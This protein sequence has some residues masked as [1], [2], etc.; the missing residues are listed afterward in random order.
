MQVTEH[1]YWVG[2]VSELPY[3][4]S[5]RLANFIADFLGDD[6]SRRV[7]DLGCGPANFLSVLHD[8]GFTNLVGLE[9][10]PLP[11]EHLA[12]PIV[13]KRDLA[14]PICFPVR[15]SAI[16]L[17]VAEHIPSEHEPTLLGNI[18]AA[19]A[20]GG[21]LVLSWAL[22]DQPGLGHTNGVSNEVAIAKLEAVGFSYLPDPTAVARSIEFIE[23]EGN[24]PWFSRTVLCF[25]KE[26]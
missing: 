12:Y 7:Y 22:P 5:R 21:R 20:T 3:G 19:C 2:D 18:S 9:G 8:R 14:K 26:N 4:W 16:C 6:K 23:P 13:V 24:C 15:G 10:E 1:G 17:E 11:P 25:R